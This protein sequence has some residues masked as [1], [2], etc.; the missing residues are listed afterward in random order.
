MYATVPR[1]QW[2]RASGRDL[3][4]PTSITT[5]SCMGCDREAREREK[6][7]RVATPEKSGG[8][9]DAD[10][11]VLVVVVTTASQPKHRH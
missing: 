7:R 9:V 5:V 3:C 8:G 2:F 11:D 4:R 1:S 6:R 10:G